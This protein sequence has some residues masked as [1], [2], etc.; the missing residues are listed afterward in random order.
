MSGSTPHRAAHEAALRQAG[1][2]GRRHGRAAVY[3]QI[4][5]N[6][7]AAARE[8][9]Q[10]LLLGIG[11]ADPAMTGLYEVPD[12]TALGLR[13]RQPGRRPPA[14]RRR[15]GPGPGR[16]G[17]PGR[18]PRG[19]LARGRPAGPP[20]P[21]FRRRRPDRGRGRHRARRPRGRRAGPGLAAGHHRSRH[22]P[23]QAA[24]RALPDLHPSPRRPDAPRPRADRRVHPAGP[25][26]RLV[27]GLP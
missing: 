20:P 24:V 3:W 1:N 5:D 14:G 11:S 21:R 10:E 6:G 25:G 7:T 4:G 9:Y 19:V 2:L 8:F 12:L 17:V 15:P 26:R 16:P 27:C 22:R 13:A 18:S 23:E